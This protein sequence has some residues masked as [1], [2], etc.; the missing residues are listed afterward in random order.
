MITSDDGSK[1]FGYYEGT[2]HRPESVPDIE[3]RCP[4]SRTPWCTSAAAQRSS[5]SSWACASWPTCSSSA[6]VVT[7]K[8]MSSTAS[9]SSQ[10]ATA[11]LPPA[12]AQRAAQAKLRRLED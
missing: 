12:R 11:V 10:V 1:P 8:W 2:R 7:T 6:K 3:P 5:S 4:S 9:C